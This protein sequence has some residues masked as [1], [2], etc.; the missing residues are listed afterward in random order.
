MKRRKFLG[1]FNRVRLM[2]TLG[3]AV[4]LPAAALIFV[5][6]L[7]LRSF[8]RD[9]LLEAA[10]HRDFQE[11][12]ALT[13]KKIDK[14]VY[15][16]TE[17]ARE[18]FPSP[19]TEAQEKE[20]NLDLVL[21]KSPWMAHAFIFDEQGFVMRSRPEEMSDKYIREEHDRETEGFRGWFGLE[22][23][24]LVEMLHKKGRPISFSFDHTQR[25]GNEA[26]LLTAWF[27]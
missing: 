3:L 25:N 2:L 12:L 14:K 18:L 21:S 20:Q 19:D 6:F 23:K 26:Y 27:V 8:D 11:R 7:E 24:S 1:G 22:D 4:L 16:I 15:A 9:K 13:E 17:E 10:I 5:N